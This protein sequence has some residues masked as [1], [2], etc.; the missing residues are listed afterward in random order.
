MT[1][2]PAAD[3]L[4]GKGRRTRLFVTALL[5]ALTLYA[6][7]YGLMVQQWTYSPT[8]FARSTHYMFPM[9]RIR[10]SRQQKAAQVIFYPAFQADT[11]IRYSSW[12][13]QEIGPPDGLGGES[14]N[15]PPGKFD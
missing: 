12:H 15:F 3:G 13:P 5:V 11:L 2:K 14:P 4:T 7:A 1:D 6:A 9:Y 10:G 8:G